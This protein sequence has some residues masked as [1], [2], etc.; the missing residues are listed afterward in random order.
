[1]KKRL[2]TEAKWEFAARGPA[3]RS[4]P[5]GNSLIPG[6]ANAG[7]INTQPFPVASYPSR[8]TPEGI[9][10][11]IG[12][13]AEWVASDFHLYPGSSARPPEKNI[14]S[15]RGEVLLTPGANSRQPP[16]SLPHR[17]IS[18]ATGI[19]MCQRCSSQVKQLQAGRITLRW[20]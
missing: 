4:Y 11:L 17:T 9:V 13:V 2:P 14:R 3:G 1:M 10:D 16:G 5:W 18:P 12:N 15:Y 7:G 20:G 19:S 8:A 6:N